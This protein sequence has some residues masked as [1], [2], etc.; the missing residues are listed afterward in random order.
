MWLWEGDGTE[1]QTEVERSEVEES[2]PFTQAYT[3]AE[4]AS[5]CSVFS[6]REKCF[7]LNE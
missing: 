2:E 6:C 4:E 5:V 7:V 1:G 3:A